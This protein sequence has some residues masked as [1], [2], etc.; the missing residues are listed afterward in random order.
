[1]LHLYL[2]G[3]V[4]VA[5]RVVGHGGVSEVHH[6]G[7][8]GAEELAGN[9]GLRHRLDGL[10]ELVTVHRAVGGGISGTE[11]VVTEVALHQSDV[12]LGV[13]EV[14]V[15]HGGRL[16]NDH[17]VVHILH[18]DT[19]ARGIGHGIVM[20][21]TDVGVHVDATEQVERLLDVGSTG[22]E[23]TDGGSGAQLRSARLL[24][25]HDIV[26][27]HEV[28]HSETLLVHAVQGGKQTTQGHNWLAKP[29]GL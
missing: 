20:G 13:T 23:I 21:G 5:A 29:S 8:G 4:K 26:A 19:A 3:M 6:H 1:M 16:D 9:L 27:R 12:A 15:G 11:L 18:H 14:M 10:G 2:D 28:G 25:C 24:P 22:Q 17:L 7:P